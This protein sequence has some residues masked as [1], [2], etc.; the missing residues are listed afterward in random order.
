MAQPIPDE[1]WLNVV[2]YRHVVRIV[3]VSDSNYSFVPVVEFIERE[4]QIYTCNRTEFEAQYVKLPDLTGCMFQ[5]Y[6]NLTNCC[7]YWRA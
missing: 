7:Y 6:G 1:Q 3:Y 2:G 5:R 4:G